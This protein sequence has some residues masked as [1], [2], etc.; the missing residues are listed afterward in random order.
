MNYIGER[1]KTRD[2]TLNSLNNY[3][4]IIYI[5]IMKEN[6]NTRVYTHML[7]LCHVIIITKLTILISFLLWLIHDEVVK[8]HMFYAN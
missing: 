5:T 4:Y 2:E 6:N 1:Y 8:I 7:L 3:F